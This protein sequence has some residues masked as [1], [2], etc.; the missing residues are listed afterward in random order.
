VSCRKYV[1]VPRLAATGLPHRADPDAAWQSYWSGI[2]PPDPTARCCGTPPP[3]RSR[4]GGGTPLRHF[5]PTLPVLDIGCG[6]GR[7][8]RLLAAD[9]PRL[10]PIDGHRQRSSSLGASRGAG[11]GARSRPRANPPTTSDG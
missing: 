10:L 3:S 11:S 4:S 9:Y 6:S 8:T 7:L 5:D 2:T 1:L